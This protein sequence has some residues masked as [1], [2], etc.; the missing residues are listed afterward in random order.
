MADM[1]MA[2][3]TCMA[4]SEFPHRLDLALS[5]TSNPKTARAFVDTLMSS[6]NPNRLR[7][8]IGSGAGKRRRRLLRRFEAIRRTRSRDAPGS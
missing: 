4:G 5:G 3:A 2:N 1:T 7:S 6:S 8:P